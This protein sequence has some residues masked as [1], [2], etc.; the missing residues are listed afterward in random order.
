MHFTIYYIPS[1]ICRISL[2]S[3][4]FPVAYPYGLY[5]MAQSRNYPGLTISFKGFT[6]N[7]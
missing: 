5:I 7:V 4:V 6:V 3:S 1:S 2:S